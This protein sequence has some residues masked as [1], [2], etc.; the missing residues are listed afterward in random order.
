[1]LQSLLTGVIGA[2][3]CGSMVFVALAASGMA[4]PASAAFAAFCGLAGFAKASVDAIETE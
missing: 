2:V 1:M 4:L 3:A